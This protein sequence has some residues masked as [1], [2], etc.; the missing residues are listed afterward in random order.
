MSRL[1]LEVRTGPGT[2]VRF[3]HAPTRTDKLSALFGESVHQDVE[4]VLDF[5][6]PREARVP[7]S[8]TRALGQRI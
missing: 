8:T 7:M 5:L 6:Y 3:A 1:A 2:L 4:L